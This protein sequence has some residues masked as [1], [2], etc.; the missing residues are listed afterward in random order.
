MSIPGA[1]NNT[2]NNVISFQQIQKFVS[3]V[4][5]TDFVSTLSVVLLSEN[6]KFLDDL[7]RLVPVQDLKFG[8]KFCRDDLRLLDSPKKLAKQVKNKLK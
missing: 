2:N 1:P 4:D 5:W 6:Y 3:R 7:L 8:G